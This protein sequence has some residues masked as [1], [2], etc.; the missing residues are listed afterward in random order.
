MLAALLQGRC[1]HPATSIVFIDG[2]LVRETTVAEIGRLAERVAAGMRSRGIVPGDKVAVQLTNRVE[3]AIAY[4]AVLLCGAVLV[5][6]THV[7]AEKE[8]SFIFAESDAKMIITAARTGSTSVLERFDVYRGSEA[9]RH[10]V[11][12]DAEPGSGYATWSEMIECPSPYTPPRVEPGD[13][14]LLAYSSGTT[15]APKGVLHSHATL[16]A[17]LESLPR[18]LASRPEDVVLVI[19]PPGHVAGVTSVLRPLV[20][21]G[22]SVFMHRW[23][24]SRAVDVIQEFGVTSTAGAPVHLEGILDAFNG[25]GGIAALREFLLGAATVTPDLGRR[26]AAAGIATFRCYG[27]TEQPTVT[28]GTA[29]DDEVSRMCTD[30]V[31]LSGNSV[32]IVTPD[33][34]P[35]ATGEDGEVQVRGPDQ[36][37]GYQDPELDASA[38]TDDGWFR[39]GDVGRLDASGRLTIVGRLKDVVIRGGETISSAQVEEVLLRHPAVTGGAVTGA[40]H[41][42]FGEVVAAVVTL[43]P[44]AELNLA[45]LRAYFESSGLARPKWPEQ[46]V[47]TEELPRTALGKVKKADLRRAHF[48]SR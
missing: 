46:L 1:A 38:F 40:P 9:E 44:G 15:S 22:R 32:R 43:R 24:P 16:L 27:L 12:L 34:S 18:L 21:G 11:L 4:Q 13:V 26:A 7:Y 42:R 29:T 30:G 36:F 28:A 25:T 41:R 33:G 5:P 3:C 45:E 47:I 2:D 20:V 37:I 19:F 48:R 10:V 8:L 39:T 6:I 31:A 35:A 23:D 17:E 14:C